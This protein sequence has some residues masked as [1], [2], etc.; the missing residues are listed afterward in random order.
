VYNV[1]LWDV[2][3]LWVVS[4][5]HLYL[6]RYTPLLP[7]LKYVINAYSANENIEVAGSSPILLAEH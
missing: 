2:E 5:L 6:V 4:L 7:R 1:G 3:L